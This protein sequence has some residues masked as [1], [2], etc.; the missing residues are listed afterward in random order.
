M[1][2]VGRETLL[3]SYCVQLEGEETPGTVRLSKFLPLM[4]QVLL[5]R[6]FDSFGFLFT[7]FCDRLVLIVVANRTV[8][9]F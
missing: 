9:L 8:G 6:R 5:E 2:L 4:T 3:F 7:F 1:C